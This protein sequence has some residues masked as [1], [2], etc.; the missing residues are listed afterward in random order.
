MDIAKKNLAFLSGLQMQRF[1]REKEHRRGLAANV[2]FVDGEIDSL[3]SEFICF[4]SSG[5]V[6]QCYMSCVLKISKRKYPQS[7]ELL[8]NFH[9]RE[10][11]WI[12]ASETLPTLYKEIK[13]A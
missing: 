1:E 7:K 13:V 6:S 5:E 8:I 11:S 3:E 12:V 9:G 2:A 10:L 4:I